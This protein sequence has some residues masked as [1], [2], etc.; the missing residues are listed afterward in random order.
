M[1]KEGPHPTDKHVGSRVRMRRLM[2]G[3]S[4]AQ[5]GEALGIVFQQVHKYENGAN[6]I[7]AGRLQGIS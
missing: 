2:L 6:R 1:P 5:L 4:Q 3:L 7:S